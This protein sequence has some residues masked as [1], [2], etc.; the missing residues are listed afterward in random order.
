MAKEVDIYFSLVPFCSKGG[1]K[2]NT[3]KELAVFI[4]RFFFFFFSGVTKR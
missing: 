2:G 4:Y 1:K 3:A